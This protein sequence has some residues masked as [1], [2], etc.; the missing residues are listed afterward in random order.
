GAAREREAGHRRGHQQDD[1]AEHRD[2]D[3]DLSALAQPEED[4]A[5]LHRYPGVQLVREDERD[6]REQGEGADPRTDIGPA[7]A[8]QDPDADPEEARD[9]D[10]VVEEAHVHELSGDPADQEKLREEERRTRLDEARLGT[11]HPR[12]WSHSGTAS[13]MSHAPSTTRSGRSGGLIGIPVSA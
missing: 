3:L 4:V 7:P 8:Q 12:L 2:V 6:E 10:E 9:E 5:A 13:T 11:R 1:A